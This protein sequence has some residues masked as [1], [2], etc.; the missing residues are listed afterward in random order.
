MSDQQ[1]ED[2]AMSVRFLYQEKLLSAT[3]HLSL[4]LDDGQRFLINPLNVLA[5]DVRA[6]QLLTVD[7][8][9]KVVDGNDVVPAEIVIHT[10]IYKARPDVQSICHFHAPIATTFPIAGVKLEP[11][12][13]LAA[14]FRD[15]I[16]VHPDP[17]LV[18]TREQG[19]ALARSLAG[20]RAVIMRGHG[21]VVVGEELSACVSGC[22][23]L[24][25][26]ARFQYQAMQIG[27][28]VP[29]SKEEL[30]RSYK[31]GKKATLRFWS[32]VKNTAGRT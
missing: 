19:Q 6:E 25:E 5:R 3:G 32:Y 8:E 18:V 26:N 13:F 22:Y 28:H 29:L 17:D 1:R 31:L 15:G 30:D 4:R 16:N 27:T 14:I 20:G 23:Y 10:E 7:L 12:L 9:G 2:L 21:C 11:V 24:E